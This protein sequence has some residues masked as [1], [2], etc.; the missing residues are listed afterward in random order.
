[1][2]YPAVVFIDKAISCLYVV[3][4]YPLTLLYKN[5]SQPGAILY[6]CGSFD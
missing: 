1:M 5:G 3:C 2:E 6:L 4:G